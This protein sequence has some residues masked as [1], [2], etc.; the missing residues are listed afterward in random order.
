M[1]TSSRPGFDLLPAIRAGH[2]RLD[3]GAQFLRVA[4]A[5]VQRR[6]ERDDLFHAGLAADFFRQRR[7]IP[8][9]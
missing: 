4:P 3:A 8:V 9:R 2:P 6:A 5:D 7:Q 1:N